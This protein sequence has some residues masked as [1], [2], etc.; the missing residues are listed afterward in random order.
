MPVAENNDQQSIHPDHH[1][2]EYGASSY[3]P[4]VEDHCTASPSIFFDYWIVENGIPTFLLPDN[5]SQ[6]V[7]KLFE[8]LCTFL[9]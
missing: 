7:K 1:E 4:V 6:F 8:T 2:S 3:Y 9:G 5:G